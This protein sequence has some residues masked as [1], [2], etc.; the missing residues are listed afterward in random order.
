MLAFGPVPSRR[1]GRS[2]GVNNIP[3]K[4]CSYAC[5]YCQIGKTLKME[6]ERRKFYEPERIYNDVSAKVKSGERIDY[7][8]FVPD[9]EPTLDI[10]L[11]KEAEMLRDFGIKLAILTNSSLIWREDVREDLMN[12]DLVSLKLDAVSDD[13][14]RKVNRPHKSLSLEKIL[15]GM[16]DFRKEFKG[17]IITETMLI[18]I[19]YGEELEKI[20]TF[21]KELKPDKAYIAIPTR[22]PAES[23]VKPAS[24]VIIN[25]AYQ[26]FS[27]ALGEERVEYLIGYEGNAFAFT[28]NVEEDLLSITAVHPMREEAV[29]ELLRKAGASWDVVEKMIKE[30]KLIELEYN[31]KKFYM[32]KLGSR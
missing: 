6:V 23:W 3:A 9:G 8:T 26:L 30:G 5:V 11:G 2:L 13:I 31:G 7:I 20:A 17:T 25:K 28:G 32:R 18:N 1:L 12:F 29:R 15:E 4:I 16:L 24:E 21:L 10:N 27:E 19:D 14:W 22:P